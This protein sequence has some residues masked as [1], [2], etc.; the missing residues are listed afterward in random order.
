MVTLKIAN[1]LNVLSYLHSGIKSFHRGYLEDLGI[2]QNNNF[3]DELE[4]G[5]QFPH[6]L[7][8]PSEGSWVVKDGG[9]IKSVIEL[10]LFDLFGVENDG[11]LN[12][13]TK[14]EKWL[15][16]KK[17]L[18]QVMRELRKGKFDKDGLKEFEIV[19][20]NVEWFEDIDVAVN[21]LIYVGVRFEVSYRFE[22]DDYKYDFT[23]L[24]GELIYP[25]VDSVDYEES[26]QG[27]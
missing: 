16:L 11:D 7:M 10:R 26:K 9:K 3:D 27:V 4:L 12:G 18:F 5:K 14:G 15:S 22:C 24:P 8:L 23:L 13:D 20:G 2:S 1:L 25:I 19:D 17:S 6:L 21:V